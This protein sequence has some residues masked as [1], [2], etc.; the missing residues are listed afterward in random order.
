MDELL[1]LRGYI[2][3][4]QYAEALHLI[5]EMEEMSR[6]DKINK[7]R[8]FAKILLIHLIKQMAENRTTRSWDVSIW[9]AVTEIRHV[10][11]RRKS[12][13]WY[14][15]DIGL[16]EVID[17]AYLAALKRAS[18]EAFGGVYDEKQLRQQLNQEVIQQQALELILKDD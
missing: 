11:K 12:G 13:G 15:D 1:E 5:E 8:S 6:E 17:E 4:Q 14:L 18:L 2:E 7:I 10:N 9:N 16:K 3:Q